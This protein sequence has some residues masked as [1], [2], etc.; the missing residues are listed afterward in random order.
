MLLKVE[1]LVFVA[2]VFLNLPRT[3]ARRLENGFEYFEVVEI[4]LDIA[5][6]GKRCYGTNPRR[7]KQVSKVFAKFPYCLSYEFIVP[8]KISFLTARLSPICRPVA[9][10]LPR[11]MR[12]QPA[13]QHGKC[14]HIASCEAL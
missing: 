1:R 6:F 9:R 14:P 13:H 12:R 4:H 2:V 7:K 5:R 3:E 8:Y 10:H 11:A